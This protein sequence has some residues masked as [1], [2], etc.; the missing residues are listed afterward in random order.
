[1]EVLYVLQCVKEVRNLVKKLILLSRGLTIGMRE[2]VANL[3]KRAHFMCE[4]V[5]NLP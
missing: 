1:M 5:V 2:K 3:V 4:K